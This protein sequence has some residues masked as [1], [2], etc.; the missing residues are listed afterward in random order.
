MDQPQFNHNGGTIAFSPLDDDNLYVGLGDG[1]GGGGLGFEELGSGVPS[2]RP[3]GELSLTIPAI[4]LFDFDRDGLRDWFVVNGH[5][6]DNVHRSEPGFS[7]EQRNLLFR[8][9]GRGRFESLGA[10]GGSAMEG[11]AGGRG[12]AI[13]D[14]ETR[15][16]VADG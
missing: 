8:G 10:R 14:I 5:L 13:G 3:E 12:A 4:S 2:V 1:G 9:L 15:E 7:Y 11:Q 6:Q 16:A